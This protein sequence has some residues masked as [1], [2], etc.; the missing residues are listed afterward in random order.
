M[1]KFSLRQNHYRAH[2][3]HTAAIARAFLTRAYIL[4]ARLPIWFATLFLHA[5]LGSVRMRAL[6]CSRCSASLLHT[7]TSTRICENAIRKN[8]C[9]KRQVLNHGAYQQ[10]KL[11]TDCQLALRCIRWCQ[12][13]CPNTPSLQASVPSRAIY[14]QCYTDK[15][16]IRCGLWFPFMWYPRCFGAVSQSSATRVGRVAGPKIPVHNERVHTLP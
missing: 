11:S 1:L 10:A 2:S 3:A 9:H 8:T 4:M 12:T 16:Q 5:H 6:P 7:P 14:N 15:S 13:R